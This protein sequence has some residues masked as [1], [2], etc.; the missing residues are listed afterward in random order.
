MHGVTLTAGE[1]ISLEFLCRTLEV[2]IC[3]PCD[4]D[5]RSL[6]KELNMDVTKWQLFLE[7]SQKH[8]YQ[9]LEVLSWQRNNF[10]VQ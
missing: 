7:A 4:L 8:H 9:D 2:F 5:R 3:E 1:M 6:T 10:C